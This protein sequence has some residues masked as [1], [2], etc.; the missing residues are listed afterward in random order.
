MIYDTEPSG[1]TPLFQATGCIC[2]CA[3]RIL[4]L[5]RAADKLYPRQWGF[6]G[7]KVEA[8]ESSLS[9]VVREMHEETGIVVRAGDL[10]DLG[11][12]FIVNEQLSFKYT[13]YSCTFSVLPGLKINASE[14]I[15]YKWFTPESAL[16]LDLV[17]DVDACIKRSL[18]AIHRGLYQQ[19]LFSDMEPMGLP[20]YT[21]IEEPIR[22]S[23]PGIP[24][25]RSQSN[26]APWYASFGPPGA[27]KTTA[28]GAIAKAL[29]HMPIITTGTRVIL[30][31]HS[32]LN[33][34]LR[35]AFEENRSR[36]F[37]PFQMEVLPL[38]FWQSV[39]QP[40]H[41]L[42][43][44]TIYSPLAYSRALYELKLLAPHEYETFFS[45]YLSYLHHLDPPNAVFCFDC[46]VDLLRRRIKARGRLHER[47][48]SDDY[49]NALYFAFANT[50]IELS[51][52]LS[53]RW[54]DTS[55][56]DTRRL[57]KLEIQE[58]YGLPSSS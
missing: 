17:P 42:V 47:L 15:Q 25:L 29:P 56:I 14:H 21:M 13:I 16:H 46:P 4:L 9:A 28:L 52:V 27:G 31:R 5:Q 32:R 1:R 36:Y 45:N 50:A 40:S 30:N 53:V 26:S 11:T 39:S 24:C 3:G 54:I 38:R 10:V 51:R 20:P 6:P 34:Y 2:W 22:S 7:G 41:A 49:L 55:R 58:L 48:Y 37:F 43:D 18:P 19:S 35:K 8:Y 44:E 57:T 23:I 12:V 33:F